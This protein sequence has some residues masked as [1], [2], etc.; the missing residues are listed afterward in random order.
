MCIGFFDVS[1]AV[2]FFVFARKFVLFDAVFDVIVDM[3]TGDDACLHVI[4]HDL[5]INVDLRLGI[6]LHHAFFYKFG[7]VFA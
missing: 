6:C 3:G 2:V 7:K 1:R 4:A 5:A